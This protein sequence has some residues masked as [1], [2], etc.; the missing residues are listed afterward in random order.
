MGPP[1]AA[2]SS[3]TPLRLKPLAQRNDLCDQIHVIHPGRYKEQYI[4]ASLYLWREG[5]YSEV[6]RRD[7][8]KIA[9][10]SRLMRYGVEQN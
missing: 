9:I 4:S 5:L 8:D 10:V 6:K 2:L 7:M 1:S 3:S